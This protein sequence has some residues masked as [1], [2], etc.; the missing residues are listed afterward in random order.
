MEEKREKKAKKKEERLKKKEE[1][2]KE[3]EV[4]AQR[5]RER[6]IDTKYYDFTLVR[7]LSLIKL[8]R[9]VCV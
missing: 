9:L 4:C 3:K 6:E 2:R 1:E 7:K 5:E 8:I